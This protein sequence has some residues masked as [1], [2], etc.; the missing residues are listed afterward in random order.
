MAD[1]LSH[2]AGVV[3]SGDGWSARCPAHDDEHQSL[4]VHHRDGKWLIKCHAGCG[5][6]DV[7][8]ALG[9]TESD[10]FDND[11]VGGP[12]IPSEQHATVQ[13][14]DATANAAPGLTLDQYATAK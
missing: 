9:I 3:S 7:V 8:A 6:Q 1:L 4:S 12:T 13:R 10:L 14:S 2:L 11:G 5:Y